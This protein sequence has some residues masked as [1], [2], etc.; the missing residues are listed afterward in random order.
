[1]DMA[2][3]MST[4]YCNDIFHATGDNESNVCISSKNIHVSREGSFAVESGSPS[5]IHEQ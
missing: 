1:M 4:N 2:C 3:T 5:V